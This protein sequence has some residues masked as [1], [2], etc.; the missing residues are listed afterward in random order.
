MDDEKVS[1]PCSGM[2]GAGKL[3]IHTLITQ[4]RGYVSE[5]V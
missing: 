4:S 5:F 2:V 3:Q 1:L